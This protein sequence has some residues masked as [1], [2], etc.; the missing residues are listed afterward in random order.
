[1]P[2]MPVATGYTNRSTTVARTF[3]VS[4]RELMVPAVVRNLQSVYQLSVTNANVF[5]WLS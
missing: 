5:P 3:T 4:H 2:I 1:M